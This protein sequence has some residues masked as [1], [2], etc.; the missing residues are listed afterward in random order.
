[1][2]IPSLFFIFPS[3]NETVIL[4]SILHHNVNFEFRDRRWALEYFHTL[5]NT[6]AGRPTHSS[7]IPFYTKR[8]LRSWL[9]IACSNPLNNILFNGLENRKNTS[10]P[11]KIYNL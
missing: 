9:K 7:P 10:R 1:M 3:L 8:D 11:S 6:Y 2:S 5:K 4:E